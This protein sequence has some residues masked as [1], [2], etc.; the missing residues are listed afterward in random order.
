MTWKIVLFELSNNK[1]VEEFIKQQNPKTIAKIAHHIDLL[2]D[3]GPLLSMPHA[4]KLNRNIYELRI[5]GNPEIRI[6]Y[7]FIN[8]SIYLLHAFK[9]QTQKTHKAD[10]DLSIK[11][12]NRLT[13]I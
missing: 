6:S 8:R 3:H 1:P 9:K 10:I 12:F 2:K 11:R 13:N 7:A 5:R 4:K